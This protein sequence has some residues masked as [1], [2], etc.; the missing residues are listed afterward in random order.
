MTNDTALCMNMYVCMYAC[1][2][3]MHY[4]ICNSYYMLVVH[5][6]YQSLYYTMF[7]LSL[8]QEMQHPFH[9]W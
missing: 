3:L 7:H 9:T 4:I 8:C 1:M 6:E 2:Y 5:I